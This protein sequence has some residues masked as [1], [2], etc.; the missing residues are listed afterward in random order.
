MWW[1]EHAAH[2]N[3]HLNLY[4][5]TLAV[6]SVLQWLRGSCSS[7]CIILPGLHLS[8]GATEKHKVNSE[9]PSWATHKRTW[10]VMLCLRA[11]F[12]QAWLHRGP[13]AADCSHSGQC[14]WF[15]Q[16]Q[17]SMFLK[18]LSALLRCKYVASLCLTE[19][20]SACMEQ[21]E[22]GRRSNTGTAS[23]PW[24]IFKIKQPVQT[25]SRTSHQNGQK[26]S[27]LTM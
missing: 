12:H 2:I 26:A 3:I 1:P 10:F 4:L 25:P 5:V 13:A 8:Y 11:W 9:N 22:L 20:A 6:F 18:L 15:H 27:H 7:C 14:L 16:K 23:S 19:G 21:L 17:R 24:S